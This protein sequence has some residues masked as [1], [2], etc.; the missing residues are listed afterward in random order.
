MKKLIIASSL[1]AYLGATTLNELF[2]GIKN[3]PQTKIDWLMKKNMVEN[4]KSVEYSLYPKISLSGSVEHFNRYVSLVPLTPTESAE[5]TKNKDS[6][7]F[8]QNVQKVGIVLSMPIYIREIYKNKQKMSY[9]VQ[10]AQYKN[11]ISL[12]SREVLII[13]L[14]SNYD[15]LNK[16]K[17]ALEQKKFSILETIKAIKIGVK[18]GAIP[19]FNLLRLQDS[20]NQIKINILNTKTEIAKTKA[21]IFSL[22]NV[23][24]D[25]PINI[26]G[27]IYQ[28]GD[29]L[30][31][32]PLKME[33]LADQ[34]NVE[35]KKALWWPK[36]TL[37]TKA[38][39]SWT[40]AYNTNDE[41]GENQAS[42]GV[43]LQWDLFD[44]KNNSDIQKAK[45]SL[46]KDTWQIRKT[47][48]ELESEVLKLTENMDYIKQQITLTKHSLKIKTELL[49]SAKVAFENQAMNV[50]EYLKYEDDLFDTKA[51]LAKL[52]A[53]KN[54]TLANIAFIYGNDITKVF[55]EKK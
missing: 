17:F 24:I 1:V 48:Q 14:V 2:D 46:N 54:I 50:D 22:T 39:R 6:L 52:E 15:Y 7:P 10:S 40:K 44:R 47:R 53:Q 38:M 8:G 18:N 5:L 51:N 36:I 45:I 49:K 25:N 19:E 32:K 11:K 30:K 26:V 4:K 28:K 12:L 29:F 23:V 43:Y 41:I 55:K 16:L 3:A 20:L 9:L 33:L 27:G 31:I 13:N 37:Q 42:V 34:K 21:Q 35:A